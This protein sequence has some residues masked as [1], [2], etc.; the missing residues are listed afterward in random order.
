MANLSITAANVK[1]T[2]KASASGFAGEAITA[3]QCV[4]IDATDANKVKLADANVTAKKGVVGIAVQSVSNGQQVGYLT[5]GEITIGATLTPGTPY[6]LSAT[7]GA[8]CLHADLT[9]LDN[10]I[11]I[12]TALTSALL[13]VDIKDHGVTL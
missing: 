9:T 7:A 8:I 3:G 4:Y 12:G 2:I 1:P 10:V 5:S 13:I 6:Y 11:S